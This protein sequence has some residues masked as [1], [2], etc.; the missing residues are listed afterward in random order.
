MLTCLGPDD[1]LDV[2][3]QLYAE[4][5]PGEATA[6]SM[7][8]GEDLFVPM[9]HLEATWEVTQ[10]LA[11]GEGRER[12]NVLAYGGEATWRSPAGQLGHASFDGTIQTWREFNLGIY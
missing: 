8:R 6:K 7:R 12:T 11:S 10:W 2:W 3:V 4:G 1:A 5:R 9:P